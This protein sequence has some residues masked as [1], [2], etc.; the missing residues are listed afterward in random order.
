MKNVIAIISLLITV[1]SVTAWGFNYVASDERVDRV[2]NR[3]REDF[4]EIKQM[5]RDIH[6]YHGL[7]KR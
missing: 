7:N 4:K 1:I 3:H 5:V 6:T 2:E